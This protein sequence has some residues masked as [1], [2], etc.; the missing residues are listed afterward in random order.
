MYEGTQFVGGFYFQPPHG[1]NWVDYSSASF[2]SVNVSGDNEL[3]V[4]Y[5]KPTLDGDGN[6]IN[7]K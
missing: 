7:K 2:Y 4:V 5:N 3:R 1:A 6:I